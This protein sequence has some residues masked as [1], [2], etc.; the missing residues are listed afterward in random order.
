MER[1]ISVRPVATF[2]GGR[3][4]ILALHDRDD[5]EIRGWT[6]QDTPGATASVRYDG[7]DPDWAEM[8]PGFSRTGEWDGLQ[9]A[10]VWHDA[11]PLAELSEF[12]EVVVADVRPNEQ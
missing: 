12:E 9:G 6:R 4:Q 5:Q 8:L 1:L 2:H 11:I 3:F 10:G 7:D